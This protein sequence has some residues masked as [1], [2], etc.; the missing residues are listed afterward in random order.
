VVTV[1]ITGIAAAVGGTQSDAKHQLMKHLYQ[2]PKA[3]SLADSRTAQTSTQEQDATVARTIDLLS[4]Y[5]RL[6]ELPS[7]VSQRPDAIASGESER[8]AAMRGIWSSDVVDSRLAEL[9][10]ALNLV[11][12]DETYQAYS[13][14]SI[15]V[16]L[17][18]ATATIDGLTASVVFTGHASYMIGTSTKDDLDT[19]WQVALSRPST[20]QN[21]LL[22][23]VG[24]V[25]LP[26]SGS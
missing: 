9:N 4:T 7:D 23:S 12:D 20:A 6:Q 16:D 8:G 5:C 1:T 2:P 17:T 14:C 24:Q 18:T 13:G 21:W 15:A 19:Q 22:S 10:N 11:A 3:K 25:N 26:G